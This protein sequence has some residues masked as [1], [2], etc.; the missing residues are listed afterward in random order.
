M[1]LVSKA[2]ARWA[3]WAREN[4]PEKTAKVAREFIKVSPHGKG[5]YKGMPAR[6]KEG[7]AVRGGRKPGRTF[8]TLATG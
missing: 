4:A 5:A 8:G 3:Y 2:Q 7:K 6:V 1:P